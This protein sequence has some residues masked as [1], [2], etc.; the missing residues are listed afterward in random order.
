MFVDMKR[1]DL[2]AIFDHDHE[3]RPEKVDIRVRADTKDKYREMRRARAKICAPLAETLEQAVDA[4]YEA[5][6]SRGA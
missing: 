1:S 5:F 2:S 3:P 4:L 6:K